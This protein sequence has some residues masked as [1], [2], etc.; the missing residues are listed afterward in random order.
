M[1][2]QSDKPHTSGMEKRNLVKKVREQRKMSQRRLALLT[3]I[4]Q[5]Q[6]GSIERG[7]SWPSI[8]KAHRIAEA[9]QS[10]TKRLWPPTPLSQAIVS[11][12]TRQPA[13]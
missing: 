13:A 7:E 6:I 9:L 3:G 11:D 4:A 1:T 8:E 12:S 2:G 10:T 5:S